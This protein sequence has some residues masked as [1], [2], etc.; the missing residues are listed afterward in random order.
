MAWIIDEDGV[1]WLMRTRRRDPFMAFCDLIER[2][3]RPIEVR[4]HGVGPREVTAEWLMANC[5]E[6]RTL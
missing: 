3:G 6:V 4:T 1:G 2:I 5:K